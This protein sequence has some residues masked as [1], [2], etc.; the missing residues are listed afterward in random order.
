[1]ASL[2]QPIFQQ[3]QATQLR[4][5]VDAHGNTPLMLAAIHDKRLVASMLLW[6]GAERDMQNKRG[7]TALHE[8]AISGAKEMV[9]KM[10]MVLKH[11]FMQQE[12]I[13]V[14]WKYRDIYSCMIY[15]GDF[16]LFW[17]ETLKQLAGHFLVKLLAPGRG[18]SDR[19]EW[20][21]EIC[22]DQKCGW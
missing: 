7:N 4:N 12:L 2:T 19:G 20:R 6:G 10:N 13:G 8:A 17:V 9:N 14:I 3:P 21:W 1:M 16:I 15:L 5:L 18:V 11:D 22:E